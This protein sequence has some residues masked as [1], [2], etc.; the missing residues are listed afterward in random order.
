[1]EM[2]RESNAVKEGKKMTK[3]GEG[4]NGEERREKKWRG[5]EKREDRRGNAIKEGKRR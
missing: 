4:K 2:G 1:M 5:E 3:C